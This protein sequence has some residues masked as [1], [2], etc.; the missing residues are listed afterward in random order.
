MSFVCLTVC[1]VQFGAV[2][3]APT[4]DESVDSLDARDAELQLVDGAPDAF[5][6]LDILLAEASALCIGLVRDYQPFALV[7]PERED[8]NAKHSGTVPIE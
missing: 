3:D 5:D 2:D 8:R 7:H 4:G 1:P 6:P